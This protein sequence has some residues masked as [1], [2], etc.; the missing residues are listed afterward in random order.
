MVADEIADKILNTFY[1]NGKIMF[2][3]N[4]GS[5]TQASHFA[6]ELVCKY[7]KNR[8][9]L[10]AL[11]LT[12]SA[13]ITAIANDFGF[14][15]V[16]SRQVWALGNKEDLLVTLSTSGKSVNVLKA[17]E[18]AQE[19]GIEVLDFPRQGKTAGECQN[20][21]VKLMHEVCEIVEDKFSVS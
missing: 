20:Y 7:K 14:E 21:Q 6:G 13:L 16:F 10:P 3:G 12:D 5:S 18:K 11:A 4:G 1:R 17:I 9:P 15:Y 2:I 19:L 8:L